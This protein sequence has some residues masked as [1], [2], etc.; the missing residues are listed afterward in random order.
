LRNP[1]LQRIVEKGVSSGAKSIFLFPGFPPLA[2]RGTLTELDASNL[3]T[4]DIDDILRMTATDWQVERFSEEKELDYS[5]GIPRLGRFRVCAFQNL[6][7]TAL[8]MR[9][10][11]ASVPDFD[12]LGLPA[13]L[14]EFTTL[15]DGLVLVTG[16]T[17]SGK[18]TTLAALIN[19][20]NHERSC[21]IITLEDPI[22]YVYTSAKSIISQRE[23][24]RDTASFNKALRRVLREDPDVILV[25][26]IRDR[27]SLAAVLELAET[28]HLV[29]SSLH[30]STAAQTLERLLDLFP[31]EERDQA[32]AQVAQALR[33]VI[34]QK[35]L[36]TSD[37]KGFVAACEV[38]KVNFAVR[39]LIRENKVH[40]IPSVMERSAR[41]GMVSMDRSLLDLYHKGAI[42]IHQT[43]ANSSQE[44]NILDKI[45][46]EVPAR[47][48][49]LTGTGALDLQRERAIYAAQF[50][51][52]RFFDASGT[53]LDSPVG[54]LFRDQGRSTEDLHFIADYSILNG[55]QQPFPL[56]ALCSISYKVIETKMTQKGY[57]VK[58]RIVESSKLA[59]E[60][61]LSPVHLVGD[62]EWHTLTIPVGSAHSG[63]MVKYYMLLFDGNITEMIIGNMHFA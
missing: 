41:E 7:N 46:A 58:L 32:K 6:G 13:T 33:G 4:T 1:S 21:H 16:P 36:R 20:I 57:P 11:P 39:N 45:T 37:G 42:D 49:A 54:L 5:Y 19:I 55:N 62:G 43:I 31:A 40:Q 27:E 14:R 3:A 12:G 18:S 38:L 63:K 26:E 29:F 9:L 2:N 59:I 15:R 52:L 51:D 28:G 56:G 60:I 47:S 17:G 10:I 22:E 24:G 61:P 50:N 8:V 48:D 53:L 23:I 34:C 35:L 44:R 30:T 25:G